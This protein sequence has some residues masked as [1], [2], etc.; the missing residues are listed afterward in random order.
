[1]KKLSSYLEKALIRAGK[2][3]LFGYE[4]AKLPL[5]PML[6]IDRI[7]H[8]SDSGGK[9]GKGEI[10]AEMD[11][12]PSHWFFKCHFEGDPVMPGCLGLDA[13]WQL[14]GFFLSWIG[15]TGKGR[16]LG[17]GEVSFKGQVRPHH[18][19]ITYRLDIKRIIKRPIYMALADA[20]MEVEGRAIYF[21]K[22]LKVGLFKNLIYPPP[23]GEVEPF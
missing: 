1:M 15:G 23:E 10:V 22:N 7:R 12:L 8:I 9:F 11:I 13:L 3:E 5:P 21:A 2:G 18:K 20:I 14:T 17:C 6:M 19:I 4:N 16:A